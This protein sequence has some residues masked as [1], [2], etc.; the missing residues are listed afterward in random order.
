VRARWADGTTE[1]ITMTDR[2]DPFSKLTAMARTTAFTTSVMA[3]LAAQGGVNGTGV[4][5]PEKIAENPVATEFV[6]EEMG[7]RGVRF[8]RS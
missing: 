8:R 6:I 2:Y 7:K 5:P 1:T 4:L 3:Q